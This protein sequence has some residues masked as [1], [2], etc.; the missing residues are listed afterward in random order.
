MAPK[1]ISV[2]KKAIE[3]YDADHIMTREKKIITDELLREH[4]RAENLAKAIEN[5]TKTFGEIDAIVKKPISEIETD[6]VAKLRLNKDV[7]DM[8]AKIN[9]LKI[10]DLKG[11]LEPNKI[12]LGT[13]DDD[14]VDTNVNEEPNSHKEE[15]KLY[16]KTETKTYKLDPNTKV[17]SES[18]G[19]RLMDFY[20]Q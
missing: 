5:I 20:N 15:I 11:L 10:N 9:G 2:G 6:Q 14:L 3:Q 13:S 19:E 4:K 16:E 17:F 12:T 8:M 18:Y 1:P 7:T